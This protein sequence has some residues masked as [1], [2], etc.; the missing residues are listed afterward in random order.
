M[1]RALSMLYNYL[2]MN[3]QITLFLK[4]FYVPVE[5]GEHVSWGFG[6]RC[7]PPT[8]FWHFRRSQSKSEPSG[9]NNLRYYMLISFSFSLY[10]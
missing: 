9:E 7:K 5:A 2:Q 10:I 8:I 6:G 4:I 1:Y 3:Y